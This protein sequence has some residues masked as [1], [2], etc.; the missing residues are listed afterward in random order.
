M[1][2]RKWIYL[3]AIT[4]Y[5]FIALVLFYPIIRNPIK[6]VLGSPSGDIYQFLFFI[7]WVKYALLTLHTSPYVYM[8]LLYYPIGTSTAFLT[9]A[10]IASILSIPFQAVS[11]PF[12]YN[13]VFFLGFIIAGMGAFTL[14]HYITKDYYS[15]FLGGV[16]FSFS[17]SFM[18]GS[19]T[20]FQLFGLGVIAFFIYFFLRSINEKKFSLI[21]IS[22]LLLMVV[23]FI[24]TIKEFLISV[25]A[26]T[27]ILILVVFISSREKHA[28]EPKKD[29]FKLNRPLVFLLVI[30]VAIISGLWGFIPLLHG[31][32]SGYGTV[33]E[34]T[35]PSYSIE[36]SLSL[37]SFFLPNYIFAR[38]YF[39]NP[40][41]SHYNLLY[42]QPIGG[43]AYIGYSLLFLIGYAVMKDFKESR[44]WLGC[45]VVFGLLSLGPYISIVN[46]PVTYGVPYLL[47]SKLP[48]FNAISE[49]QVFEEL[50][51]LFLAILGAIG[52]R[53][54]SKKFFPDKTKI[55]I[56]TVS[57]ISIIFILESFGI[58]YYHQLN[59]ITTTPYAPTFF[60]K[61]ANE[62]GN[63]SFM[64]LPTS[65]IE[66]Y[67][68][69][70]VSD[71]YVTQ[72]HKPSLTGLVTR[73]TPAQSFLINS[74][75]LANHLSCIILCNNESYP[76]SP[77]SSPV[78]EN[79]AL[80]S[81]KMLENYNVGLIIVENKAYGSNLSSTLLYL[82]EVFGNPIYEDNNV[83][84]FSTLDST[85]LLNNTITAIPDQG[86]VF[87]NINLSSGSISGWSLSDH[88]GGITVYPLYQDSNSLQ[89]YSN[90]TIS[91]YAST[92]SPQ[93]PLQ[94]RIY[95]QN[96]SSP[97]AVYNAEVNQANNRYSLNT[98]LENGE[99][100]NQVVFITGYNNTANLNSII[101]INNITFSKDN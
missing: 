20:E 4:L 73:L 87:Q 31:Y 34:L 90:V 88:Y 72:L 22:G 7:W 94:I 99:G 68:Y 59:S 2:N 80:Q 18:A 69:S 37:L 23:A 64:V 96:T 65:T 76:L 61:I 81:I 5:F 39:Q 71:Y 74:L 25:V 41:S 16:F 8:S 100:G 92:L 19:T 52:F 30:L 38:Y 70:G 36:H 93:Q 86:W 48:L 51:V 42:S 35:T 62:S 63:F 77:Y 89:T 58:P 66:N 49:P 67:L 28:E 10:P 53:S 29:G 14:A 3:L 33:T 85:Q 75:P 57:I 97:N 12:A 21:L 55:K 11:L 91:F 79:Y 9:I 40:S 1:T 78:K 54:L 13:V 32:L 83:T 60:N 50:T 26:A 6:T 24:D 47:F 95:T 17:S 43:A 45:A 82:Q 44:I 27:L 56:F 98:I 84:L 15:A 46:A 101:L